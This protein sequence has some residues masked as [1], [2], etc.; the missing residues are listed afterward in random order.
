MGTSWASGT[1]ASGSWASGTWG[2]LLAFVLDL[3]TRL[4]VYLRDLYSHP[5]GDLSSLMQRN[6]AGRT[7]E[8]TARFK[9][10]ERDALDAML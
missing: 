2:V 6:L 10:L 7:G 1:W 3:N 5:T 4:A 9:A 8:Y